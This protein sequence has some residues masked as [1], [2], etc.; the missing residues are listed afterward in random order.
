MFKYLTIIFIFFFTS[1]SL[2]QEVTATQKI[3]KHIMPGGEY[4]AEVTIHKPKEFN[5][6]Y[7]KFSQRLPLTFIATEINSKNGKFSFKDGLVKIA[8]VVP[9]AEEEFIISFKVKVNEQDAGEKVIK[10]RVYYYL[11]THKMFFQ[12]EPQ[13]LVVTSDTIVQQNNITVKT[14][15]LLKDTNNLIVGNDT[16]KKIIPDKVEDVALI[17]VEPINDNLTPPLKTYRVQIIAVKEK[18]LNDVPEIFSITDDNGVTKY[19]SGNFATYEEAL[20]RKKYMID[21][22][23][24]GSFIVTFENGKIV[25]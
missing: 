22:G 10:G 7:M 21:I 4:I 1:V 11:N 19:Y 13:T 25:K 12:L 3:P 9:P 8:W 23:F 5:N 18:K 2:S 17:E 14:D 20:A 24:E 16:I 6:G 15:Y